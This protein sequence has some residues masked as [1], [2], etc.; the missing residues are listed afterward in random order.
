MKFYNWKRSLKVIA[1]I[2]FLE[3]FVILEKKIKE[4]YMVMKDKDMRK[5]PKEMRF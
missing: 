5:L 4:K 2:T 3:R 1:S